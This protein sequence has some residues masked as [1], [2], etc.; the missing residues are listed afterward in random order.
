MTAISDVHALVL[1]CGAASSLSLPV[2]FQIVWLLLAALSLGLAANDRPHPDTT[3][4]HA[5]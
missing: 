2:A 5:S 4:S 1:I 3:D